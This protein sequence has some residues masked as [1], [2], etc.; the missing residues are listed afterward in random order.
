MN[1]KTFWLADV[2]LWSTTVF[3]KWFRVYDTR[4]G[5]G[6][7]AEI[8]ILSAKYILE[9]FLIIVESEFVS[10]TFNMYPQVGLNYS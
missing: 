3:L 7:S 4:S 1:K 8:I 2:Q 9:I 10:I 6:T 5:R